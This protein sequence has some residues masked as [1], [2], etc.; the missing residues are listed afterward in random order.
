MDISL[1]NIL[2]WMMLWLGVF[3]VDKQLKLW[4]LERAEKK[5]KKKKL[6]NFKKRN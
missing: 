6:K 5:R 2:L 1:S 4:R 3:Q